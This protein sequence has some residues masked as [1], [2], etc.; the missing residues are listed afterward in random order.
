MINSFQELTRFAAFKRVLA[1]AI[2]RARDDAAKQSPNFAAHEAAKR[3][4]KCRAAFD[5]R[6]NTILAERRAVQAGIIPA[7]TPAKDA[8]D[9]AARIAALPPSAR[10]AVDNAYIAARVAYL[11]WCH[12]GDDKRKVVEY[13]ANETYSSTHALIAFS[14]MVFGPERDAA[15]A[16]LSDAERE[17]YDAAWA[18]E[19]DAIKGIDAIRSQDRAE[20]ASDAAR[21]AYIKIADEARIAA[22]PN[23]ARR[24]AK[25]LRAFANTAKLIG[26]ILMIC[27]F[28]P[29]AV[30]GI[31]VFCLLYGG[32]FLVFLPFLIVFH[33]RESGAIVKSLPDAFRALK[34]HP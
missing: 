17:S 8:K 31:I 11:A 10:T 34:T 30:V 29:K 25:F 22:L 32:L 27:L 4:A 26:H 14:K 28:I 19:M 24:W 33:W 20:A 3:R 7:I 1:D 5:A 16:A 12:D 13:V 23:T 18:A 15:R 6:V 21:A 9:H 2:E